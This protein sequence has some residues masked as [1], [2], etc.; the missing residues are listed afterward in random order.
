MTIEAA[1]LISGVSLALAIYQGI[2]N[3]KRNQTADAKQDVSEITTVIVKLEN[4]GNG[5]TEIK[6]EMS[7]VKNDIKETRERLIEVK[8]SA[9]QAHKRIDAIER[10]KEGEG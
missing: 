4:I 7:S 1:L 6:S 2:S 3:M 8:A 9:K 10:W 5:I